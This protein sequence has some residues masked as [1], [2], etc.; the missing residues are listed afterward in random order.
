[1]L[2]LQKSTCVSSREPHFFTTCSPVFVILEHIVKELIR[3]L[4]RHVTPWPTAWLQTATL[5]P[6]RVNTSP[7]HH[8]QGK[9]GA[10]GSHTARCCR[11]HISAADHICY[12]KQY[13]D[14]CSL[15]GLFFFILLHWTRWPFC[16]TAVNVQ[17]VQKK[18]CTCTQ[19]LIHAY[20]TFWRRGG[21]IEC[22]MP[23]TH[24]FSF[25]ITRYLQIHFIINI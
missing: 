12:Q 3:L 25:Y 16:V 19:S 17:S 24:S 4:N 5:M 11:V 15:D 2:I 9:T 22:E 8:Y 23:L 7:R 18:Q 13:P 21:G 6:P 10:Q 20:K 14:G 1:M